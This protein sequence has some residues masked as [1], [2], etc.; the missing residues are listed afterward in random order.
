MRS[1]IAFREEKLAGRHGD[2]RARKSELGQVYRANLKL[3]DELAVQDS[4]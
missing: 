4:R 3:N 1:Q 2:L